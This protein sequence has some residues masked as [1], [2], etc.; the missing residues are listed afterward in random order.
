MEE[1]YN[2]RMESENILLNSLLMSSSG[3]DRCPEGIFLSNQ[4]FTILGDRPSNWTEAKKR[5]QSQG[6]VL[7]EPSDNVVVPLRRLLLQGY[8]G[9]SFWV[10]AQG[11][12]RTFMWPRANKALESD[13]P[14]WSPGQPGDRATP[15]HCLAL[16]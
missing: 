11:N 15:L 5:C 9:T 10:N 1:I 7:A 12:L 14:L 3:L 16:L 13:S 2:K 6:L 4:C 8:G